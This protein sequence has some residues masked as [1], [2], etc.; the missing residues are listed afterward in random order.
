MAR[1]PNDG[2]GWEVLAPVY[3]RLGRFDDAVGARKK[4]LTLN[5]PTAAR[6]A[7]LGEAEPPPRTGW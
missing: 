1:N 7:D 6:E 4:A 2:A 5:G 3:A